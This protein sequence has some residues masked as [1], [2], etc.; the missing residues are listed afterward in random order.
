MV[1][2][3]LAA[4]RSIE[5]EKE[6]SFSTLMDA[7][8]NALLTAY[9]HTP[10]SMPHARVAIDRKSG[11]VIVWAQDLGPDGAIVEEY[12]DTPTDFGRVAAATA[13]QVI[14][15]RLRD[16]EHDQ[17]FGEYSGREGDIVTGVIQADA[18]ASVRGLV[19]V[20]IGKVE[21]IL[22]HSEQVPG[23]NYA[24]GTRIKAY[25][26]G[27]AR[28]A[29]GPQV[30]LSRTHPNLVKKL[31]ALEVPEI[32]DG[33]V[34]IVAVA[35][36]SGH[37]SKIA[38]RTAVAGLNAKGACIGPMGQRV[39]NVVAELNG[40]KIDIIDWTEDPAAFVGNALSPAHVISS[41]LVDPATSQVRV[42]VPD[43]QLSLAIG[44]EGQ[45]ARLAA[46]L[47]GHRIDIH[48]DA[49]TDAETDAPAGVPGDA[50]T[51][52]GTDVGDTGPG[53]AELPTSP[54]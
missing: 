46:R 16:A 18:Q 24:H 17:T 30:T 20:D 54:G 21:A 45:N 8:E 6:I 27:V 19:L 50:G 5:R 2:V 31:F 4:L 49:E 41:R 9:K 51:D 52:V 13:R 37:R 35:R 3:D 53:S 47:T 33:S 7:L 38:V 39:R 32:A 48:S 40:E 36:E 26:V 11:E 44:R 43:F 22:P 15:Q 28:G 12:D 29:R 10:H 25:V 34:E 1:S 42:V 23:E 14:A